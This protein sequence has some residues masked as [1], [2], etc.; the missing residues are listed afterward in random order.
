MASICARVENFYSQLD[1]QISAFRSATGITCPQGCSICCAHDVHCSILE[2]IPL[3]VNLWR[4][5]QADTVYNSISGDNTCIFYRPLPGKSGCGIYP[6]RGYICR[7][8]GFYSVI[9]KNHELEFCSCRIIK[10]NFA[11]SISL[12]HLPESLPVIP[13]LTIEFN[14]IETGLGSRLFP[15][16]QAIRQAIEK[17]YFSLE[18]EKN[19]NQQASMPAKQ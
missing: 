14:N 19:N 4:N 5:K 8:F 12:R 11:E 15:V 1:M 6:W 3:A 9:N 10:K 13:D 17:V 18:A 7:I 2:F 16:N